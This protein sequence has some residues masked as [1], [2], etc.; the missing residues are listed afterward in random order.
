MRHSALGSEETTLPWETDSAES[1]GVIPALIPESLC[2]TPDPITELLGVTAPAN[3][4]DLILESMGTRETWFGS[5]VR[6]ARLAAT[7]AKPT[8]SAILVM[9]VSEVKSGEA[10]ETAWTLSEAADHEGREEE[11]G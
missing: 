6:L 4:A 10:M 8:V 9:D 5:I 2:S 1:L 7:C 11:E 3:E